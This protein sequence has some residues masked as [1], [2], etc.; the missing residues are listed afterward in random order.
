MLSFAVK[1]YLKLKYELVMRSVKDPLYAQKTQLSLIL[2]EVSSTSFGIDHKIL[3]Y[4][5]Y[6]D[7]IKKVPIRTYEELSPYIERMLDGEL[8]VLWH[9]MVK[10]FAKSSGTTNA[11]S[12]YLPVSNESY[13]GCHHKGIEDMLALYANAYPET[14][15]FDGKSIGITGSL[16][17]DDKGITIGDISALMCNESPWWTELIRIPG[18]EISLKQDWNEKSDIIAQTCGDKDVRILA[19]VPTW[20][21]VILEKVGKYTGDDKFWPNLELVAHGGVAFAPYQEMFNSLLKDRKINYW[22]SYN[23][24]EGY[25]ATQDR[26]G[27]TDMLLLLSNGVFY[28]F[29]SLT[30]YNSQNLNKAIP[31]SEVELGIEYALIITT[32]SGLMRYSI[33]DTVKF[34]SLT[35]YSIVV[36]GRT[37]FFLNAFGEEVVVEN[38][39]QAIAYA[40]AKTDSI[41]RH[42][43]IAPVF[44]DTGSSGGHV[45]YVEFEKSPKEVAEFIEHIDE[46]LKEI[47]SDYKAKRSG[48]TVMDKPKI[49]EVPIGT[50]EKWL[51]SK[52]KLGGQS[53]IPPLSSNSDVIKELNEIMKMN[54]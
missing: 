14:E 25:F 33:G 35:P 26:A 12:K 7:F 41:I 32:N 3:S 16:V 22:Q 53:K 44:M 43:T 2:Q 46:K 30:D 11:A 36:T 45:W 21:S 27:A 18:K 29:I 39:T 48:G 17:T 8:N 1:L 15:I 4:D 20:I 10:M 37:K 40:Q 28:E 34:T 38:T 6:E 31:L 13:S 50:F 47:N 24:S 42:Y 5:R 23:A 9:G 49:V 52:N 54:D 19:G 51:K